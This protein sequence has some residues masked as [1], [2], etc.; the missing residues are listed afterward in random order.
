[1]YIGVTNDLKRRLYEH[2]S[3]QIKG[4]TNK[5]QVHKLV[6]FEEYSEVNQAIAREKQLKGWVRSKKNQLVEKKNPNWNDWGENWF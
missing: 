1:M 5:Y 2:K 3:D 6:Y 4:F